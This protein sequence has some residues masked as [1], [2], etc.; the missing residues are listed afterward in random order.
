MAAAGRA[1]VDQPAHEG[2][3]PDHVE[4]MVLEVDDEKS[5]GVWA[6]ATPASWVS[7]GAPV[8][9]DRL[10][11]LQQLDEPIDARH[12]CSSLNVE[13]CRTN[14]GAAPVNAT[15]TKGDR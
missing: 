6:A 13:G 2:A 9:E 10:I 5:S 11:L 1:A 15:T 14:T 12:G 7:A 8:G 3:Q 4:R